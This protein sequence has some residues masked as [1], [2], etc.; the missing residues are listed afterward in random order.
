MGLKKTCDLL[1]ISIYYEF[2]RDF[3]NPMV[4]DTLMK[5]DILGLLLSKLAEAS[6][7]IKTRLG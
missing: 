7:E 6:H 3:L 2:D 1:R 5:A 4:N